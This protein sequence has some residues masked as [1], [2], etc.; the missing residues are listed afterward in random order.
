MTL[1]KKFEKGFVKTVSFVKTHST[2]V[3]TGAA[4]TAFGALLI[5]VNRQ[6]SEI[7]ELQNHADMTI[8]LIEYNEKVARYEA[9]HPWFFD[10]NPAAKPRRVEI[11]EAVV[12]ANWPQDL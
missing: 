9:S 1:K 3:L 2:Q 5:T 4:L 11:S 6:Q 7:K 8:D 12:Q 10:A